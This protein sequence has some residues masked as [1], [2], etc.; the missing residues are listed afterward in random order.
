MPAAQ[1]RQTRIA[2]RRIW[3]VREGE[4]M[5]ADDQVTVEEPLEIR[6]EEEPVAVIMRTP[7]HD[8]EL[9]AGF[10]LTEGL[11]QTPRALGAI[12]YCT[13]AEPPNEENIVEVRMA[14]AVEFDL[15]RLKRNF[16][17]SS[18]CGVCGKASI[19]AIRA[20]A[21]SLAG[22]FTVA[23]DTLYGLSDRMRQAQ[24]VFEQ[25]GSLH[26]AALCEPEGEFRRL[27][28]D[29]GR[30]NAVDKL[31]GH[32]ALRNQ[33]VPADSV[34]MVSG[35]TSFEIVQKALMAGIA[36][37]CAV[38]APSSLAVDMAREA[39]MTLVGFLRGRAFN[40]YAGEQRIVF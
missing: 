3:R 9:A 10:L 13:A 19:E 16:Y 36:V 21:P 32:Y 6:V 17:A 20:Q 29:V 40:A 18:S 38:S 22:N 26:A 39:G 30:H 2:N 37:V 7:R 27:R 35:R 14:A 34:L 1:Q 5:S 4:R 31:V 23:A 12:S 24:D 15:A 28:E 11:I 8:F 33:P 25:T